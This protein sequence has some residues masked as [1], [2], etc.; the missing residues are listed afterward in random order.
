MSLE[1]DAL[2]DRRRLRRRISFWRVLAF[3]AIAVALVAGISLTDTDGRLIGRDHV[4]RVE[5]Q[6]LIVGDRKQLALLEKIK[7]TDAA[8][9]L[10]VAIDSPGGTTAGSEALYDAIRDV[11]AEKPVVSVLGTTA[12]SGGY[13][14][15]I[16]GD[17]IIT[18]GNT[19]TASIG[20]IFSWPN[21]EELLNTIGVKVNEVKSSPIKAEPTLHKETSEEARAILR[22]MVSDSQD[23]FR[24]LV[25]ERRGLTGLDLRQAS[26]GRVMTG[27]QAIEAGL[28]D[29]LGG[30]KEAL[31][32]LRSEHGID[33]D[34]KVRTY[35]AE[36]RFDAFQSDAARI[37]VNLV[38]AV[39]PGA[40]TLVSEPVR[41]DGL[42]SIWQAE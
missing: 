40:E 41:I 15:A 22:G 23:W 26:D 38:A 29:A 37:L 10:I 1:A 42:I 32:W 7:E 6:G 31:A 13:I 8:K 4:A 18:R 3:L 11:A 34:V 5:V 14:A 27:R 19:T 39:I 33:A 35:R 16:A 36:Q 21:A 12:A 24:D 25:A 20:V 30:E 28:A 2:A 9:A 17:H